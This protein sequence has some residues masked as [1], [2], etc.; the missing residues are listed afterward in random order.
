MKIPVLPPDINLSSY[1]FTIEEINGQRAIRFGLGAIKN[2]GD[3]A[4]EAILQVRKEGGPFAD[5]ADFLRRVRP[6][7]TVTRAVVES[8]IKVGAFDS[9][10]PNRNQLLQALEMLWEQA[11]K[12]AQPA[13]GQASL[14][15]SGTTEKSTSILL[16]PDVPD[17]SVKEKLEWERELLGVFLSANPLQAGYRIVYNRIT[18][19]LDELTEVAP[20]AI[21]RIWGMVVHLRP[22]VDRQNRPLLF[23]KL[24]DH[25]GAEVELILSGDNYHAFAHLFE[26]DALIYVEGIVRHEE[27]YRQN[28]N[29]HV[30]EGEEETQLVVRISPRYVE[31]FTLDGVFASHKPIN[32]ANDRTTSS[33]IQT[34]PSTSWTEL[35]APV[36]SSA[37]NGVP[38]AQTKLQLILPPKLKEDEAQ[39]LRDLLTRNP[40]EVTVEVVIQNGAEVKRRQLPVKVKLSREFYRQLTD[41]LGKDAVQIIR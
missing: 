20:G 17:V 27:P 13:A 10:H 31:R 37:T 33:P 18:H 36:P 28:G 16:L 3:N 35:K 38:T 40:G 24:Q 26:K 4:V 29:E 8:L 5:I 12:S 15:G 11:G 30:E 2:V 25:S 1:D 39:R 22:T 14:F 7:R 34:K 19:S 21:V 41:L 32:G 23:A 6:H 9:L